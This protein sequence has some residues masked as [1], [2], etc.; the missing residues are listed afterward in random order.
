MTGEP[1][2]VLMLLAE[3]HDAVVEDHPRVAAWVRHCMFPLT[4]FAAQVEVIA[5]VEFTDWELA[6]GA[7]EPLQDLTPAE[8]DYLVTYLRAQLEEPGLDP[9]VGA[10]VEGW[11]GELEGERAAR[12]G[13]RGARPG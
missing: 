11:V 12:R 5:D 8:L 13:G 7:V 9:G 1:G 2:P 6:G 3:L 4:E 10:V